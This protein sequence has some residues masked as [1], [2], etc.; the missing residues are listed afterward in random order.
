MRS[1]LIPEIGDEFVLAEDWSFNLHC[2]YRNTTLAAILGYRM[3]YYRGENNMT[4]KV[5]VPDDAPA[6][7]EEPKLNY[8]TYE[9]F[10]KRGIFGNTCDY[11]AWDKE[12]QRIQNESKEFQA[13]LKAIE[14]WNAAMKELGKTV[15]EVTLKAGSEIKVDRVYIR[16]G[17]SEF[18]SITWY[19]KG[20][21][22]A[23]IPPSYSWERPRKVKTPRFWTKLEDANRVKVI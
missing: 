12:R 13:Y 21:G 15:I 1:L 9:A 2:E 4:T 10:T 5:W 17:A 20:L 8:P 18:S 3:S 7:P 6:Y 22:E 16:K 19:V 14:E 11:Q 23:I